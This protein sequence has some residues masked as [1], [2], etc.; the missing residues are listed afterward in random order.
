MKSQARMILSLDVTDIDLT[1]PSQMEYSKWLNWEYGGLRNDYM[2][3]NG[4]TF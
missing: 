4:R 1:R 2:Q 3:L